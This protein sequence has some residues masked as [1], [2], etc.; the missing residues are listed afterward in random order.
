L[1]HNS[2]IYLANF[3]GCRESTSFPPHACAGA[4]LLMALFIT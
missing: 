2:R 4:G 3:Q 1:Q